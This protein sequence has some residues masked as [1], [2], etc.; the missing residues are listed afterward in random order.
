MRDINKRYFDSLQPNYIFSSVTRKPLKLDD[1][2]PIPAAMQ[3]AG[4]WEDLT[5]S[6]K[7]KLFNYWSVVTL[8]AN[9]LQIF[10]A[11][12]YLINLFIRFVYS[13]YFVG[14]GCLLAWVTLSQYLEFSPKYSFISKTLG[15]AL[16]NV[17]RTVMGAIPIFFGLSLL[18]Q[19]IFYQT[20]RFQNFGFAGMSLFALMNGDAVQATYRDLTSLQV[21]F[22]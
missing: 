4:T 10:G 14:L 6:D 12:F 3:Y 21:L 8:F 22:S 16:P 11:L 20:F 2:N 9:I 15:Q 1:G 19:S 17:L 7:M 18:G 13:D 5:F